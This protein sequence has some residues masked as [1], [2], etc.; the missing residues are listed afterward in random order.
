MSRT[1]L[2]RLEH[3]TTRVEGKTFVVHGLLPDLALPDDD[4]AAIKSA[5]Q[6]GPAEGATRP[7]RHLAQQAHDRFDASFRHR[8][9][10]G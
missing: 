3:A 6:Q 2:R 8:Q 5:L 7:N 4:P 9:Q 10:T 1:R